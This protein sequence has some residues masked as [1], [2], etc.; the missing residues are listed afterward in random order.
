MNSS[1]TINKAKQV[2]N[3]DSSVH[4]KLSFLFGRYYPSDDFQLGV[5]YVQLERDIRKE[6]NG[7]E[8]PKGEKVHVI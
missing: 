6:I 8:I 3:Q 2:S 1:D 7:N 4:R 5:P